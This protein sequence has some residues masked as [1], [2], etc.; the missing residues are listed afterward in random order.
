MLEPFYASMDRRYKESEIKQAEKDDHGFT[1]E[2]IQYIEENGSKTLMEK[3]AEKFAS[4]H[5]ADITHAVSANHKA[6]LQFTAPTQFFEKEVINQSF[7]NSLN[8]SIFD[9]MYQHLEKEGTVESFTISD[10]KDLVSLLIKYDT[11]IGARFWLSS[12]KYRYGKEV[13]EIVDKK[14]IVDINIGGILLLDSSKVEL[15]INGIHGKIDPVSIDEVRKIETDDG[16]YK[17]TSVSGY[18]IVFSEE[19]LKKFLAE[20]LK[21]IVFYGDLTLRTVQG[22]KVGVFMLTSNK[23]CN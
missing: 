8:N 14:K 1:D 4:I 21:K 23:A 3:A 7:V 17:Y 11:V 5:G 22:G 9:W 20:S 2:K 12:I 15:E 16:K 19:E 18:P 13:A 6:L 10:D